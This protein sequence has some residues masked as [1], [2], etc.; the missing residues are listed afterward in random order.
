MNPATCIWW[1]ELIIFSVPWIQQ[2]I[3]LNLEDCTAKAI[4]EK[5]ITQNNKKNTENLSNKS[6]IST[7]QIDKNPKE[8]EFPIATL[9][10]FHTPT[11][12]KII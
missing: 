8:G 3:E 5:K 7:I 10:T 11:A 9:K 12:K 1:F 6:S 4:K 2:V